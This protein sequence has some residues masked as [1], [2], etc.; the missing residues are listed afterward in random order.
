MQERALKA[1][2]LLKHSDKTLAEISA[3]CGYANQSHFCRVFLRYF[4]KNP[5]IARRQAKVSAASH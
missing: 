2:N 4:G 1:Q 5:S 3:E